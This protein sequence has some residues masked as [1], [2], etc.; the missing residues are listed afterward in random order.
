MKLPLLRTPSKQ[1]AE[2]L[3]L[4]PQGYLDGIV[5]DKLHGWCFNPASP[6]ERI[7]VQILVDGVQKAI[8]LADE[9]RLDL[10]RAGIG[11]GKHGF[12]ID[13]RR[14]I[15]DA[16]QHHVEV[17]TVSGSSLSNSPQTIASARDVFYR[18]PSIRNVSKTQEFLGAPDAKEVTQS[19]LFDT[20]AEAKR[21]NRPVVV[22]YPFVDWNLPLFQR[23]QHMAIALAEVGVLTIYCS[24]L[25]RFENFDGSYKLA[26]NL[27]VTTEFKPIISRFDNLWIDLYSTCASDLS[28]FPQLEKHK[29]LYE[30]VDHIDPEI[31][32]DGSQMCTAIFNNLSSERVGLF[33]ATADILYNELVKR[34]GPEHTVL[35]PNGVAPKHYDLVRNPDLVPEKLKDI[36]A[37][38]RPI[39]G[40]FGAIAS[41]LDLKMLSE[42]S[43]IRQDLSFVMIGPNYNLD[44]DPPQ[45]SNLHWLGSIDYLDLARHAVWFDCCIIPFK[46]GS[47]A[48][49]TS[50]LKLFEYFALGKGVVVGEDMQEC[51]QYDIVLSARTASE[52]ATQITKALDLSRSPEFIAASKDLAET[53]SWRARA[54]VL[55]AALKER[56]KHYRSNIRDLSNFELRGF[57]FETP[58]K[59]VAVLHYLDSGVDT[60]MLTGSTLRRGDCLSL[61]VPISKNNNCVRGVIAIQENTAVADRGAALIQI[62]IDGDLFLEDRM[63]HQKAPLDYSLPLP[64]AATTYE[65]RVVVLVDL[66]EDWNWGSAL[67]L[68]VRSL[69]F[70]KS[71]ENNFA[72]ISS[73][74]A[75]VK[76]DLR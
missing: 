25:W 63:G 5:E 28:A 17:I 42:L 12:S 57:N 35:V 22:I 62:W 64:I 19:N 29:I 4:A 18:N 72:W 74:T 7:S 34:F 39:V 65:I 56:T 9:Y 58:R 71:E 49:S 31:S 53:N 45:R 48:Q 23:P 11:D 43:K 32:G 52:Y 21:S 66:F 68:G 27:F 46:A 36:V 75:L 14:F 54:A 10:E 20:I 69:S 37:K 3:V 60:F 24:P 26:D 67:R 2:A 15:F 16:E 59:H 44:E 33:L 13:L 40:Y 6:G 76:P 30:Y 50:P 55:N 41:W 73:V 8:L 1:H 61:L 70:E 47:I 51:T 38:G